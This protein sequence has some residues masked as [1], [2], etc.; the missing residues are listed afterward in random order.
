MCQSIRFSITSEIYIKLEMTEC[1][2][3]QIKTSQ[4]KNGWHT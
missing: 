3:E 1:A 4:C 2:Y